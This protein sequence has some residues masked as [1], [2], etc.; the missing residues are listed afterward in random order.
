MGV[1]LTA[2]CLM[3]AWN[4]A[5]KDFDM[6]EFVVVSVVKRSDNEPSPVTLIRGD[7]EVLTDNELGSRVRKVWGHQVVNLMVPGSHLDEVDPISRG[8]AR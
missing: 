1:T 2:W 6:P 8:E 3:S 7:A 4:V 5:K